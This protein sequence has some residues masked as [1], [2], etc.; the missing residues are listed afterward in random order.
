MNPGWRKTLLSLVASRGGAG[1]K[2]EKAQVPG[3]C[4]HRDCMWMN[5]WIT[6]ENRYEGTKSA[7]NGAFVEGC[8][9]VAMTGILAALFLVPC[10]LTS[11]SAWS[12]SQML[13]G[14]YF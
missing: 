11:P 14:L 6:E 10:N 9:R 2:A 8:T 12:K 7:K 5:S 1:T 4:S 13:C 3:F